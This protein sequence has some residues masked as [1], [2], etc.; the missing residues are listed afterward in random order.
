M[1]K[2]AGDEW[3]KIN[4][5]LTM[6]ERFNISY[7][8]S[9]VKNFLHTDFTSYCSSMNIPFYSFRENMK[10]PI[11]IDQIKSWEPDLIIAVGWYH[12]IPKCI[13]TIPKYGVIGMHASFLPNYRGGAPLVWAIINGEKEVGISLFYIEK[14]VDTG[15]IVEQ[16]KTTVN[17]NDTIKTV[18]EKIETLGKELLIKNVPL[19][20]KGVSKRKQQNY[21]Q[22]KIW[23]QRSPKDGIID[24][25]CHSLEIYN[26]IRAQTKPY[27]GAFSFYKGEKLIV[28]EAKLYDFYN[29][30]VNKGGIILDIINNEI[31]SGILISTNNQDTP[32]LVTQ[33]NYEEKDYKAVEFSKRYRVKIGE[34]LE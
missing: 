16:S 22:T 26:Y 10:D 13:R 2:R 34:C 8:K 31:V 30:Q 6:P 15:D 7:S 24:W 1:L 11:I 21:L 9:E 17:L 28:W 25:S 4:G 23:P 5:V 27:P 12:M 18:Y 33:V 19:I 14:G 32:L 20:L 29:S 3:N